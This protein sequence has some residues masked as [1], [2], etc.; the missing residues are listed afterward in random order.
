MLMRAHHR[1][2][3]RRRRVAASVLA[4]DM[5]GNETR[6][7][8]F[9]T[10]DP[11]TRGVRPL[12][13]STFPPEECGLATFTRDSAD[14]VDL[15]AGSSISMVAAI[16]RSLKREYSDA[17]VVH[18]IRNH[19]RGSY[20]EAADAVNDGPCNVV[21]LQH[22]FGLYSGT[23]GEDVLAFVRACR[24]PVVTTFH[25]LM[26]RPE[27]L[28]REIIARLITESACVVV[29]TQIAA[30]L[31]AEYGDVRPTDVHVIPHG[32]PAMTGRS[33]PECKASL[34][35]TDRRVICTFGLLSR[36]KGLEFM[37]DAMPQ[38]VAE[39]PEV[40]YRIV[41]ITHPLIRARDGEAYRESLAAKADSLGVGRHVQFVNEFLALPDLLNHLGACDVYVTP[42]PGED[43]IAS[44]TL[45]YALAAG[46]PI[47][48][49]PYVYAQ[50][51]LSHGRGSLVPF[52]DSSA[53]AEATLRY[54]ADDRLCSRT[55]LRAISY[56]IP[57]RWRNVGAKYLRLFE[58]I[59]AGAMAGS[60]MTGRSQSA[61]PRFHPPLR[62]GV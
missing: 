48:S 58:E 4:V 55:R 54:L 51:M 44:G 10:Q 56:T 3:R 25:T 23:W 5:S 59:A 40:L 13:V 36:G 2:L 30:E 18:V 20:R 11:A 15:A 61:A 32:V 28:P 57:M 22:E 42:Y 1:P 7:A 50:E 46:R 12:F 26:S 24:K 47:V 62:G 45:A 41:G 60:C 31:L 6:C 21:S 49:T 52:E 8:M 16:E 27:S 17:R 43:Q 37:I 39:C 38:I 33:N 14:A 9:R 34:G 29:M 35:L 53:L 19:E